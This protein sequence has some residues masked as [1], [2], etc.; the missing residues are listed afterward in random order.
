MPEQKLTGQNNFCRQIIFFLMNDPCTLFGGKM[1][2]HTEGPKTIKFF[3]KTEELKM[4][5]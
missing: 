1:V 3:K 2:L 4:P 5:S